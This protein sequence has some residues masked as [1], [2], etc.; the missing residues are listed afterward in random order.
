VN[1]APNYGNNTPDGENNAR[2]YDKIGNADGGRQFTDYR[3][4]PRFW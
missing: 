1:N 4:M 2:D 3:R